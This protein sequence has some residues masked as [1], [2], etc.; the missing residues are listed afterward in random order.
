MSK[1]DPSRSCCLG[2]RR[3]GEIS[4]PAGNR[5]KVVLGRDA[6]AAFRPDVSAVSSS[7]TDLVD[8]RVWSNSRG[9]YPEGPVLADKA[10]ENDGSKTRLRWSS[11][12]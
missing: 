11:T 8:E 2:S 10:D 3:I 4:D 5:V 6:A 9:V 12:S 7:L 1:W